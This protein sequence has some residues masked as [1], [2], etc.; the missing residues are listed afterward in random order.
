MR[1]TRKPANG[2]LLSCRLSCFE[3]QTCTLFGRPLISQHGSKLV[4]SSHTRLRTQCA[5][6]SLFLPRFCTPVLTNLTLNNQTKPSPKCFLNLVCA[7]LGRQGGMEGKK[8]NKESRMSACLVCT[9]W[10]GGGSEEG[11]GVER[12]SLSMLSFEWRWRKGSAM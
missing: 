8:H 9:G 5:S 10:I 12:G 7:H 6:F 3:I 11:L 2:E 1:K 4:M